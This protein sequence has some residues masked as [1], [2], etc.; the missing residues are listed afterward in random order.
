I[1]SSDFHE[2]LCLKGRCDISVK[3]LDQL[4]INNTN[5][6]SHEYIALLSNQDVSIFINEYSQLDDRGLFTS[7]HVFKNGNRVSIILEI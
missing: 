2:L 5:P 6:D 4:D 1:D 3:S 7:Q